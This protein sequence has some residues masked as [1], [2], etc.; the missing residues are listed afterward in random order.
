MYMDQYAA[1]DLDSHSM[2]FKVI[3]Y[4]QQ[5]TIAERASTVEFCNNQQVHKQENTKIC[6]FSLYYDVL[7][8]T[9]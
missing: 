6:F 4:V 5:T 7:R 3:M 9:L 1:M 2:L 8:G